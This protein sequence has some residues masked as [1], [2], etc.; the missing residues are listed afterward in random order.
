MIN[1][2][3]QPGQAVIRICMCTLLFFLFF[4]ILTNFLPFLVSVLRFLFCYRSFLFIASLR[5]FLHSVIS[6]L[7]I[8][9]SAVPRPGRHR[10]PMTAP[11]T[12]KEKR[13][14][15][16]KVLITTLTVMLILGILAIAAYFSELQFLKKCTSSKH[17]L[18][19]AICKTGHTL[20]ILSFSFL[21][22]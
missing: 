19:T 17:T 3:K 16:K 10:R 2:W 18:H 12:P 21:F 7:I 14:K 15:I 20:V 22:S 6:L 9:L 13:A 1:T 5:F 4:S 8:L 11:N